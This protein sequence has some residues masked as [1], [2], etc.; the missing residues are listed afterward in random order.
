MLRAIDR[1]YSG[2]VRVPVP[3]LV[4]C[5]MRSTSGTSLC[6]ESHTSDIVLGIDEIIR[7]SNSLGDNVT[8]IPIDNAIHDVFPSRSD[9]RNRALRTCEQ[10]L[11]QQSL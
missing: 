3:V 4:L 11:A 6:P 10:W 1:V 9:A 8:T 5:A 2:T 7:W